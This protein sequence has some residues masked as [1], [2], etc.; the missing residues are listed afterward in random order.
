V[1][2]TNGS[3]SATATV[4]KTLAKPYVRRA[5]ARAQL[6]AGAPR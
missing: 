5:T 6:L 2:V 1:T 3:G 4:A